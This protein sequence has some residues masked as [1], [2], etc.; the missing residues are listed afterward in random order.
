MIRHQYK[1]MQLVKPPIP[2][3]QYLLDNNIRQSRVDEERMLL[4][5]ICGHK[6]NTSLPHTPCDPSH[7]R[8]LRG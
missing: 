6:I 7:I 5:G 8:T 1:S 2:A 4:P 3:T